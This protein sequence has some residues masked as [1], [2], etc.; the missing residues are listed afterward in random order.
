[1]DAKTRPGAD[2]DT[3]NI[4]TTAK[5]RL[6][7]FRMP[8]TSNAP[9]RYNLDRLGN[10]QTANEYA[11]TTENRF[12]VL[13]DEWDEEASTNHIWNNMETIWKDSADEILGKLRQ[14]RSNAWI[15]NET[16]HLAAA[17]R[18]AR[19]RGDMTEYKR[20]RKE[21]QRLIRRDK[22]SC[23]ENECKALD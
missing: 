20:L 22:N 18:D 3:A 13:L 5:L 19:K 9:I 23:L 10:A 16:I 4:L 15:S 2:C 1:M 6:K 11:V 14:K 21:V 17:K 8:N 7:T 12:Q